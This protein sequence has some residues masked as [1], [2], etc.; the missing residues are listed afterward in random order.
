MG[1]S[2]RKSF[3]AGPFRVTASKSGISYSAGVKGVRVTKRANG[4][5]QTTISAPGTG[6]RYTASS[7]SSGKQQSL[8]TPAAAV[9][10][11]VTG[12]SAAR[13]D[14]GSRR[15]G[16]WYIAIVLLS[17]G[18]FSAIPFAHAAARLRRKD[19]RLRAGIY[20]AVAMVVAVLSSITPH[21]AH[22]NAVGTA[23]RALSTILA[24]LALALM[25]TA[26]FQLVPLRREVY[27]LEAGPTPPTH[28]A[29]ADPVVAAHLAAR[30]R[31]DEARALA[32]SDP[33]LAQDLR[34]GRPD[35]PR[36]YDDGGLIDL[37]S[38][39]ADAIATACSI[40][41][42]L[43]E[44]IVAAR[45]ELGSFSSLD[46]VFVFAEVEEGTAARIR[47]YGLLLPR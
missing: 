35:L 16:A 22:G 33:V 36:E 42:S 10:A 32:Q 31:R 9:N 15:P 6:L 5:V 47:E 29:A 43:A 30:A 40:E 20:A 13:R 25:A 34:I 12:T 46:E 8:A 11:P 45:Q 1:F 44:R 27:G 24:L 21:D 37:N 2:Y 17:A 28:P 7:T 3:K 26:C 39:P 4:R 19:L 18:L 14:R 23:G 41:P 38:V